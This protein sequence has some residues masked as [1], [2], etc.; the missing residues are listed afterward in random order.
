[1]YDLQ[2]NCMFENMYPNA[3]NIRIDNGLGTYISYY[4]VPKTGVD[5]YIF[6]YDR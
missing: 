4:S 6:E 2:V 1:M 3:V 5:R